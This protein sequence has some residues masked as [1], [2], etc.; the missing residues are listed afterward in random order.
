VQFALRP[1]RQT[2]AGNELVLGQMVGIAHSACY[3]DSRETKIEAMEKDLANDSSRRRS[4]TSRRL[5]AD[6]SA[7]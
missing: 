6:R 4:L 2:T 5:L 7:M 1:E 3:V